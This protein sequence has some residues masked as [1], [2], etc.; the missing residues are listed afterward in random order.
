LAMKEGG[1]GICTLG[2]RRL[3]RNQNSEKRTRKLKKLTAEQTSEEEAD[4]RC[5]HEKSCENE[6]G[7]SRERE[8]LPTVGKLNPLKESSRQRGRTHSRQKRECG[9]KREKVNNYAKGGIKI[10]GVIRYFLGVM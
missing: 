1:G 3:A 10:G 2:K 6:R 9:E 4:V 8:S 5:K 7:L